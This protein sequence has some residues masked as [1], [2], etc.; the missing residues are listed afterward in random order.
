MPVDTGVLRGTGVRSYLAKNVAGAVDVRLD[1]SE[2]ANQVI[3]FTGAITAN[4]SVI[5]PLGSESGGAW[6]L[7]NATSGAFTLTV[8]GGIGSG[9]AITAATKRIT[10]WTGADFVHWTAAL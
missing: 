8:K 9:V 7:E 4:M 3:S 5:F 2:A 10:V 6:L 1:S